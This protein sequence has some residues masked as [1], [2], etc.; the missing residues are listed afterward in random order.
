VSARRRRPDPSHPPRQRVGRKAP[1]DR[2]LVELPARTTPP[3]A[4][5][6]R[7]IGTHSRG[8]PGQSSQGVSL[9]DLGAGGDRRLQA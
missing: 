3:R 1:A 2:L 5:R 4:S 9:L 8:F 7:Q 6:R